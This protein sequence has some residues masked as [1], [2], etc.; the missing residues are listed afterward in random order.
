M[1]VTKVKEV[2][3]AHKQVISLDAEMAGLDGS[4]NLYDM[5]PDPEERRPES[6][7]D[8]QMLPG[9]LNDVLSTLTQQ[10]RDVLTLRFGLVDGQPLSLSNAAKQLGCSHE[11]VRLLEKRAMKKLRMTCALRELEDYLN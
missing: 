9:Y 5:L 1:P 8:E 3:A 10:E 11:K 2:L 7:T 4:S 6:V